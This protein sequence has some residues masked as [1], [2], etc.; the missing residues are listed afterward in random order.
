MSIFVHNMIKRILKEVEVTVTTQYQGHLSTVYPASHV[1]SYTIKITNHSHHIIQL[2]SRKWHIFDTMTFEKIVEGYGVVGK[3]PIFEHGTEYSYTSATQLDSEIGYMYGEY[4]FRD[5][6]TLEEFIVEIPSFD[7][8]V[9]QK[10][11]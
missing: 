10:Y 2:V 9:P 1:F 7:L 6:N 5:L 8:I 3:Q 4:T 11:N